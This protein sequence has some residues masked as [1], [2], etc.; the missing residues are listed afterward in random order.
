MLDLD[1]FKQ[2]N[3]TLGHPVGDRVIEEVATVLG[4][5]MRETDVLAR[6]GGDEFAIVLPECDAEEAR[7]VGETI[8]SAIRDHVAQPD[9][10]PH[11]T[12]SLGIAIFGPGTGA[13]FESVQSDADAAMYAAKG[14]G[15][16][17]VYVA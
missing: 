3:D 5:R 10:V 2:V 11:V 6:V 17:G 14:A 1:N 13:S 9:G 7:Q 15:R 16:D 4:G 12:A 8:A